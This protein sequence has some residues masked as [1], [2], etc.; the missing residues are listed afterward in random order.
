MVKVVVICFLWLCVL[1]VGDRQEKTVHTLKEHLFSVFPISN[2]L[3]GCLVQHPGY[4]DIALLV[5]EFY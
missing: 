1:F 5:L 4:P 3:G 2:Q